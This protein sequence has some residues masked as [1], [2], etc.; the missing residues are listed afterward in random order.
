MK[1]VQS[2]FD[3]F[4]HH[5][6]LK[7]IAE[8]IKV[9]TLENYKDEMLRLRFQTAIIQAPEGLMKFDSEDEQPGSIAP[10]E[11][12]PAEM[13]LFQAF[14]QIVRMRRVFIG[15]TNS[16]SHVATRSDLDK[17]PVRLGLFGLVSV[18]ESVMREMV[19]ISIDDWEESLSEERLEAARKLYQLK[20]ARAEEID[21]IQCLQLADLGSIFSKEQRFRRFG[22]SL[23][24]KA[25]DDKIRRI[26]KLRDSLAHSQE[27]LPFDWEEIADVTAFIRHMLKHPLPDSK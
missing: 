15:T 11:V 25:Y 27:I 17:L 14:P 10:D 1:E 5:L 12:F 23:S 8:E 2:L 20:T 18:L 24:R 13:P 6:P 26:G 4:Q 9:F 22:K 3:F 7:S 19:R 21:L 16:V